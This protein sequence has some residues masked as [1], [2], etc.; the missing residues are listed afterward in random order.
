MK[1]ITGNSRRYTLN[2]CSICNNKT[3]KTWIYGGE[4][5]CFSCYRK[6]TTKMPEYSKYNR[7]SDN[8]VKLDDALNKIREVRCNSNPCPG[9]YIT[10]PRV[11]IGKK[12]KLILVKE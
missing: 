1:K 4:Y 7:Y 3:R 12:V 9:G 5:L 6:K 2:R 8:C 10:L 11:L